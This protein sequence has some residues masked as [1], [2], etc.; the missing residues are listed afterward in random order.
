MTY[1]I[2]Y[3]VTETQLRV[4]ARSTHYKRATALAKQFTEETGV[5]HYYYKT[6]Y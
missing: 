5:K 3:H 6:K 1:N 2:Y 4:V